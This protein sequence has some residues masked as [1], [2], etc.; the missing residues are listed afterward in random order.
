MP[1]SKSKPAFEELFKQLEEKVALLEQGGLSL[2]DSL[3]AYE[4]AVTLAQK[5]QQ[6]LDNAELR[7][8]RLRSTVAAGAEERFEAEEEDEA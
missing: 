2:D 7:I 8:T 1:P 4:D 3:S 6:L 5:C